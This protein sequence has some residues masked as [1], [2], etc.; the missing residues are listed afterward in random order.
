MSEKYLHRDD[1]PF[2]D[3]VWES[4][5]ETVVGA[6]KSQ[7]CGRRLL[8][9]QGPYGLGLKAL[10]ASDKALEEKTSGDAKMSAPCLIPL[11]MIQSEFCLPV[12]DIASFEQ[13][14]LP[15]DLGSAAKAA[16]D[17]GLY[18]TWPITPATCR[19]YQSLCRIFR[20]RYPYLKL[21]ETYRRRQS[22][23]LLHLPLLNS[24][25]TLS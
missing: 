15:L 5:D 22:P 13:M 8:N 11:A 1:A 19:D 2:G 24:Q 9:I 17:C 20:S 12:R 3:K 4:I 23:C 25:E 6:A 7:L 10:P 14:G 21:R 18:S 16:M